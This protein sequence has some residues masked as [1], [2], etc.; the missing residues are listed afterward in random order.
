MRKFLD[1]Q[2]NPPRSLPADGAVVQSL[3]LDA[4]P[5]IYEGKLSAASDFAASMSLFTVDNGAELSAAAREE[6][7]AVNV[8]LA[9]AIETGSFQ[10]AELQLDTAAEIERGAMRSDCADVGF[11]LSDHATSLEYWFVPGSCNAT[12][13]RFVV[14]VPGP[15][16]APLVLYASFG[17]GEEDATMDGSAVFGLSDGY[18]T[19]ALG[20]APNSAAW[21]YPDESGSK[22]QQEAR[23]RYRLDNDYGGLGLERHQYRGPWDGLVMQE[24]VTTYAAADGLRV[25]ASWQAPVPDNADLVLYLSERKATPYARPRGNGVPESWAPRV[26]GALYASAATGD[27]DWRRGPLLRVWGTDAEGRAFANATHCAA[28]A[29]A[30]GGGNW[31]VVGAELSL[32]VDGADLD[33]SSLHAEYTLADGGVVSCDPLRGFGARLWAAG[34]GDDF[35]KFPNTSLTAAQDVEAS[36]LAAGGWSF[37]PFGDVRVYAGIDQPS[38]G[39]AFWVG[40]GDADYDGGWA[41]GHAWLT[42]G[43]GDGVGVV[44]ERAAAVADDGARVWW[45]LRYETTARPSTAGATGVGG[46]GAVALNFNGQVDGGRHQFTQN[47]TEGYVYLVPSRVSVSPSTIDLSSYDKDTSFFNV[48]LTSPEVTAAVAAL[49]DA[50]LGW[51]DLPLNLLEFGGSSL[52]DEAVAQVNLQLKV[53]AHEGAPCA[54]AVAEG[55]GEPALTCSLYGAF[56]HDLMRDT[57][58]RG[59]LLSLSANGGA[60]YT[61][62]A[63]ANL[64]FFTVGANFTGSLAGSFYGGTRLAGSLLLQTAGAARSFSLANTSLLV[65]GQSSQVA[66]AAGGAFSLDVS[67]DALT[68][69]L[70][71]GADSAA[72]SFNATLPHAEGIYARDVDWNEAPTPAPSQANGTKPPSVTPPDQC[73]N[74]LAFKCP[75][76]SVLNCSACP[77]TEREGSWYPCY[78]PSALSGTAGRCLPPKGKAA[79][80]VAGEEAALLFQTTLRIDDAPAAATTLDPGETLYCYDPGTLIEGMDP[81]GAAAKRRSSDAATTVTFSGG[82]LRAKMAP[83]LTLSHSR[84]KIK[85]SGTASRLRSEVADGYGFY[86]RTAAE[87]PAA[88]S[89]VDYDDV[90][91]LSQ[92]TRW[93]SVYYASELADSHFSAGALISA[94]YLKASG[95]PRANLVNLRVRLAHTNRTAVATPRGLGGR[96][97]SGAELACPVADAESTLV[98]GPASFSVGALEATRDDVEDFWFKLELDRVFAWDGDSNLLVDVGYQADAWDADVKRQDGAAYDDGNLLLRATYGTAR[99]AVTYGAAG[100]ESVAY[101]F[102]PALKIEVNNTVVLSHALNEEFPSG[103]SGTA[104]TPTLDLSVNS[105]PQ[106]FLA[107][108]TTRLV[109]GALMYLNLTSD[110]ATADALASDPAAQAELKNIVAAA[111]ASAY[112][113]VTSANVVLT[114]V[115]ADAATDLA[116][117]AAASSGSGR[118]L[119]SSSVSTVVELKAVSSDTFAVTEAKASGLH[120]Q[121]VESATSM[122]V[123]M[124]TSVT[125]SGVTA[126]VA[127]PVF[128]MLAGNATQSS[129]LADASFSI[130]NTRSIVVGSLDPSLGSTAGGTE[131][132]IAGIGYFTPTTA[133]GLVQIRWTVDNRD[134]WLT[135]TG[136]VGSCGSTS[137]TTGRK[138][139]CTEIYTEV[140][141]AD[142]SFVVDGTLKVY[143]L[144]SFNGVTY[145]SKSQVAYLNY[146]KTPR[147]NSFYLLDPYPTTVPHSAYTEDDDAYRL[148]YTMPQSGKIY[149][150]SLKKDVQLYLYVNASNVYLSSSTTVCIFLFDA[151]GGDDD[152]FDNCLEDGRCVLSDAS[153]VKSGTAFNGEPGFQSITGSKFLETAD[154]ACKVPATKVGTVRVSFSANGFNGDERAL[155]PEGTFASQ[156]GTTVLSYGC[157]PG[158][159]ATS[160]NVA[161]RMCTAGKVADTDG[162]SCLACPR[163]TYQP[164]VGAIACLA[165]PYNTD[166]NETGTD[167]ATQCVCSKGYFNLEGSGGVACDACVDDAICPGAR[168]PPYPVEGFYRLGFDPTPA[169]SKI[170]GD[171]EPCEPTTACLGGP[172]NSC[173]EGYFGDRCALC[174]DGFFRLNHYCTACPDSTLVSYVLPA[175]LLAFV[176]AVLSLAL[177]FDTFSKYATMS[178]FVRFCQ[179]LLVLSFYEISW[180]GSFSFYYVHTRG[181]LEYINSDVY[182]INF[183]P[184]FKTANYFAPLLFFPLFESTS[185]PTCP[186]DRHIDWE[187][188]VDGFFRGKHFSLDS[189]GSWVVAVVLC[190]ELLCHGPSSRFLRFK[191]RLVAL[192]ATCCPAAAAYVVKHVVCPLGSRQETGTCVADT[193]SA[194]FV[195]LMMVGGFAFVCSTFFGIA[196]AEAGMTKANSGMWCFLTRNKRTRYAGLEAAVQLRSVLLVCISVITSNGIFQAGLAIC[197]LLLSL[198]FQ[199]LRKPYKSSS[200]NLLESVSLAALVVIAFVGMVGSI[201]QLPVAELALCLSYAGY[202]LVFA[203]VLYGVSV[204]TYEVRD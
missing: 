64:T 4:S 199:I 33:K 113:T 48:T 90:L 86:P 59:L 87:Y 182:P 74:A 42:V 96:E 29:D 45:R 39:S 88:A 97:P 77:A 191:Q 82:G 166:T 125:L 196:T 83:E 152:D 63:G 30:S 183:L 144:I 171:I 2:T 11:W 57:D 25:D 175:Q 117:A 60:S 28:V 135:S 148:S 116:T 15:Q 40:V 103:V 140:P 192:V 72:L 89:T 73:A 173:A 155:D 119:L 84:G 76:D 105:Q 187:G 193:N 50:A 189:L 26:A 165:C 106:A 13:S 1:L 46:S 112:S 107:A 130:F 53:G 70:G 54:A 184:I 101:P 203:T 93:Q 151:S 109:P 198:I 178:I 190:L 44:S 21:V 121:L 158:Q 98:L 102:I 159:Y 78:R 122:Q 85:S 51:F 201:G 61:A 128:E 9:A 124:A 138:S 174:E 110:A 37:A 92:P 14:K 55:T 177:G 114:S 34:R 131:V 17:S 156:F 150:A 32:R 160:S 49:G 163:R 95:A 143:V 38:N 179:L 108:E 137:A 62:L 58:G 123:D 79:R 142:A 18:A 24:T 134:V 167:T 16:P 118:R 3:L 111:L 68:T 36:D 186:N 80:L 164:D 180:T 66:I 19:W 12:D 52:P 7:V 27:G 195:M 41:N 136:T 162:K 104:F 202:G 149:D 145:T 65:R 154:F 43:S 22:Q 176:V 10:L 120:N 91:L 8:S 147:M 35:W 99:T 20:S 23:Y 67:G 194:R 69:S 133:D 75:P 115:G 139:E 146:Y 126:L 5:F 161:C 129:F 47:L 132:T 188:V 81:L 94:L 157:S 181:V 185:M 141:K 153:L 169:L 170:T 168:A 172:E 6:Y 100:A 127:S 200:A 197:L 71:P 31:S 204:V 56:K